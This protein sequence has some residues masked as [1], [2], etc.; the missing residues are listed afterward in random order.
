MVGHGCKA[1]CNWMVGAAAGRTGP[2]C[3]PPRQKALP[4]HLR[5]GIAGE[6]AAFFELLRKGY[7]VV[8]RRWSGGNVAGDVDLIA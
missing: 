2:D 6:D 5:T 4:E 7:T 1:C 8:A 3:A